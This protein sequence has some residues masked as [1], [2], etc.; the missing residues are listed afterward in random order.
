MDKQINH[1][2]L[3]QVYIQMTP[4]FSST[5]SAAIFCLLCL[6]LYTT[7]I[8]LIYAQGKEQQLESTG[9]T[10]TLRNSTNGTSVEVAL[11]PLPY[12][13]KVNQESKFMVSFLKPGNDTLQDHVD[14]NLRISKDDN[15]LFQATNQTGQPQVPLHATDGFMTIP[16]LNYRFSEQGQYVVEIPIYGILFNPIIPEY[17]YFTIEVMPS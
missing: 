15:Q 10:Y 4:N 6:S 1:T 13:L 5:L 12:P 2:I 17:A 16:V 9:N 7:S 3:L 11:Q 14:F 8:I